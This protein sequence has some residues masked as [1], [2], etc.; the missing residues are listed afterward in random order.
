MARLRFLHWKPVEAAP[1]IQLLRK[2]GHEVLYEEKPTPASIKLGDPQALLIDLSRMPSHGREIAVHHRGRKS[3]RHIPIVFVDGDS[4][5]VAQIRKL[6]PDA[7]YATWDSI[8]S[9]IPQALSRAPA[10]PVVPPQMM[11][12]YGD[13]TVA[14]KL[15]I[16][17]GS[18]V[19]V[20]D[21]PRNYAG[22]LGELPEGVQFNENERGPGAIT[23]WFVRDAA[24]YQQSILKRR[25]LARKSK[26]WIVWPKGEAGKRAGITQNVVR[27]TALAVALVDYK[28]CA[29]NDAWS[30][31]VFA[32]GKD[33]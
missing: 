29:I 22:L 13:R 32:P 23:L 10:E 14:Q 9:V 12:R 24:G 33:S 1:K 19:T 18:A 26:L 27:E 2:A 5:K 31:I 20:I 25:S 3:T 7:F 15:G 28:I 17:A 6:I 4:E 16:K 30:A 21:P 11:T 8:L